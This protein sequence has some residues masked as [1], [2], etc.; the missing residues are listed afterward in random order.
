[1]VVTHPDG[2]H[3]EG[4]IKLLE[5]FPPNTVNGT[6]YLFKFNGPVLITKFFK[7]VNNGTKLIG[8]LTDSSNS[9]PFKEEDLSTNP[10]KIADFGANFD[11]YFQNNPDSQGLILKYT[12][13]PSHTLAFAPRLLALKAVPA[14]HTIDNSPPNL[15]SIITT[16]SDQGKHVIVLTG[17]AP[18]YRVLN[19][20]KH[21]AQNGKISDIDFF[22]IPH[23]GSARNSL[24]LDKNVLPSTQDITLVN[25]MILFRIVLGYSLK[26]EPGSLT[27]QEKLD[28]LNKWAGTK[29]MNSLQ[30]QTDNNFSTFMLNVFGPVVINLINGN[31][32][33]ID[34][35]NGQSKAMYVFTQADAGLK[36]VAKQVEDY[37]N[38]PSQH[39]IVNVFHTNYNSLFKP[40]GRYLYSS[41]INTA[42]GTIT[43][44][45]QPPIYNRTEK[46]Y[47][48]RVTRLLSS[49]TNINPFL[50]KLLPTRVS[51]MYNQFHASIYYIS[52]STNHG[53]PSSATLS[54]VIYASI[55][56][57][58]ACTLLLSSG[59]ALPFRSLPDYST[60]KNLVSI[61]YFTQPYA[62]VNPQ[63]M[64]MV[65]TQ[66]FNPDAYDP[67]QLKN[68]KQL[69]LSGAASKYFSANLVS[70]FRSEITL[71]TVTTVQRDGKTYYLS[72][73]EDESIS[74]FVITETQTSL[75]ASFQNVDLGTQCTFT[76]ENLQTQTFMER[77]LQS[78]KIILYNLETTDKKLKKR[79]WK[80][81]P[82][83][84]DQLKLSP[85]LSD[86]ATFRFRRVLKRPRDENP[87]LKLAHYQPSMSMLA[88]QRNFLSLSTIPSEVATHKA[89]FPKAS[90]VVTTEDVAVSLHQYL[91]IFEVDYPDAGITVQQLFVALLGSGIVQQL[92]NLSG[93]PAIAK[94]VKEILSLIVNET[95]DFTISNDQEEVLSA[96]VKVSLNSDNP[97]S[98]LDAPIKAVLFKVSSPRTESLSL[99]MVISW[100]FQGSEAI[101]SISKQL[102][103]T[104]VG[105]ILSQFLDQIKFPEDIKDV[106]FGSMAMLFTGSYFKGL[107]S[108][109]SFPLALM[110]KVA[111]WKVDNFKSRVKSIQL[112][113]GPY[114]T[115][116][117]ISAQTPS[118]DSTITFQNLSLGVQELLLKPSSSNQT[119][120]VCGKGLLG[121]QESSTLQVTFSTE[122]C[123]DYSTPRNTVSV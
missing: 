49:A 68:L 71:Y 41:T 92:E 39:D 86:A 4:I 109:T 25:H 78:E 120:Q 60:W 58:Q 8:L 107:A 46:K 54:G 82:S 108:V 65:S 75:K 93:P 76:Y 44:K 90:S 88:T 38:D 85:N 50:N 122:P 2:D 113:S 72:L 94:V 70:N 23:H 48:Y 99:N 118:S 53:H 63:T 80:L 10:A 27:T 89:T 102:D 40:K 26:G 9:T 35:G 45:S 5:V 52:S 20:L 36:Q 115:D 13:P 104:I 1:M 100:S 24:P 95:S 22:Q 28:M 83:G 96:S 66:K 33:I 56:K 103:L 110:Q 37:I 84:K 73:I 6:N 42:L 15:S 97:I 14:R 16:W 62:E 12:P 106:T 31:N 7:D 11:F 34:P 77:S 67:S 59:Y 111:P 55:K 79:Y 98:L 43:Q 81:P 87:F 57:G 32:N 74:K 47:T 29:L 123:S 19:A 18:G 17:D 119:Y 116:F 91:E 117:V 112:A 101:F 105:E 61:R 21:N 30:D 51:E 114:V 69:L 3:I 121:H 64:E